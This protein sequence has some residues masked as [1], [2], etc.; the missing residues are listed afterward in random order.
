MAVIGGRGGG[1][2]VSADHKLQFVSRLRDEGNHK[3]AVEVPRPHVVYLEQNNTSYITQ[4]NTSYITHGLS[5]AEEYI[6][7]NLMSY[8]AHLQHAVV[9]L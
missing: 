2:R 4:N 9:G 3:T 7:Y 1:R 6:I 5:R 8:I